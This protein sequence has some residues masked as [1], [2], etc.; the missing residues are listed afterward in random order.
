MPPEPTFPQNSLNRLC[1]WSALPLDDVEDLRA[2]GGPPTQ[3][4]LSSR[5][6]S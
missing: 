3:L 1:V 2:V 5:M 4:L 6:N